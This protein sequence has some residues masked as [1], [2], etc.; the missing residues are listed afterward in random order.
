[1]DGNTSNAPKNIQF[2]PSWRM[3]DEGVIQTNYAL[4]MEVKCPEQER[5]C[6][7]LPPCHNLSK[8]HTKYFVDDLTH[9]EEYPWQTLYSRLRQVWVN[10]TAKLEP[11]GL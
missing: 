5:N 6:D 10:T 8:I 4:E 2:E 7:T 1:M 9:L 3:D 11:P